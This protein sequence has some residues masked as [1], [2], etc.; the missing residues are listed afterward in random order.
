MMLVKMMVKVLVMAGSF[1]VLM[2]KMMT[3]LV[4]LA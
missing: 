4:S 1:L 2:M 3:V